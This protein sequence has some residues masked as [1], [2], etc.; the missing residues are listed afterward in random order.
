MR[1][2]KARPSKALKVRNCGELMSLTLTPIV[3]LYLILYLI[4]GS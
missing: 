3:F 4:S 1:E 2:V